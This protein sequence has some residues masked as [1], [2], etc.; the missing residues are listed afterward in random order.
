MIK[1]CFW[2]DVM[3]DLFV[4]IDFKSKVGVL[5]MLLKNILG[6][7]FGYMLVIVNDSYCIDL[8]SFILM[9]YLEVWIIL[10]SVL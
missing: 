5:F 8:F 1:V 10:E 9:S 7:K 4:K 2:V 3:K 6:I